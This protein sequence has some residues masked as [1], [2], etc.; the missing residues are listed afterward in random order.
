[1]PRIVDRDARRREVVETYLSLVA[2]EGIQGATTRRLAAELG[3]ATGALWH[4]FS[5]FDEVL[6]RAMEL[7]FDRTNERIARLTE[8]RT[9]LAALRVM[10]EQIHP[11]DATTR[12]E[13]LVVVSFW[14][15]VPEH[16][17]LGDLQSGV[18][19]EWGR[20]YTHR[21][22]EAI[23]LGELAADAPVRDLADVLLTLV[24]G[25]QVEYA[26]Q[27][28]IASPERQWRL[29]RTVLGPWLTPAGSARVPTGV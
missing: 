3:I 14:G 12:E 17:E 8:G 1:M 27:S 6:R 23:G 25:I 22:E 21:L 2:T 28:E 19:E 26:L 9:G 24:T 29:I 18:E 11:M 4:Y 10:I 7:I 20:A 5:N 16:Q 13:A 15:R